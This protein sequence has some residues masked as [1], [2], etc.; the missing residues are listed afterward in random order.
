M[1]NDNK[2]LVILTPGWPGNEE[3]STCL[4]LQQNLIRSL[5]ENYPQ[6]QIIILSFQ[7]PYIRKTYSWNKILVHSF[8]GRNKGGLT[9]WLLRRRIEKVLNNIHH[10]NNLLGILSFWYGECAW[11]GKRFADKKAVKHFTWILGQDAKK[12]N[13]YVRR[14][15]PQP[16]E[17]IALSDFIRDE[18]EKNHGIR[19]AHLVPPGIDPGQFAQ[20][21][22]GKEIDLLGAGSLIPLKQFD[23][24]IEIVGEIK[25]SYPN[26]KAVLAG[27]G[28]EMSRL[29]SMINES[30][31]G[32]TLTL[33]GEIPHQ[34]LIQMMQKTRVFLHPSLYEGFGMVCLEA[35]AAGAHTISFVKP[36]KEEIQRWHVVKTAD[37]MSGA[38]LEILLHPEPVTVTNTGFDIKQTAKKILRLFTD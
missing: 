5:M 37:D 38:A 16:L 32:S 36:M 8:N 2:T 21:S 25:E 28:P 14:L 29:Q 27:A 3:D 26:L 18:F 4:P 11:I 24:F 7:Y 31:L 6:L 30:G 19:P 34:Q 13:K 20:T 15:Q 23:L 10:S 9:R 12:E 22:P 1:T 33:A 17:L 35:I